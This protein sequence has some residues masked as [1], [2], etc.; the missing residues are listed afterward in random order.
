MLNK[1]AIKFLKNQ[2]ILLEHQNILR[3]A[4][5]A[6][7]RNAIQLYMVSNG[8]SKTYKIHGSS[9]AFFSFCRKELLSPNAIR[10]FQRRLE[11]FNRFQIRETPRLNKL[12]KEIRS[13]L[14]I[15]EGL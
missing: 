14:P 9:Q 1:A 8:S 3:K 10:K 12:L 6:F 15:R 11:N 13:K 4:M 7:G 2:R 5:K